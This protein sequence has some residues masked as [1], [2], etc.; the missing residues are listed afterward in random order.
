MSE[1]QRIN[2][3]VNEEIQGSVLEYLGDYDNRI[4]SIEIVDDGFKFIEQC[5][6]YF[7][8][9]LSLAEFDRFIKE[10]QDLREKYVTTR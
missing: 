4:V 10:L 6:M 1:S 7:S 5:D 9:I 8:E 2:N 3:T